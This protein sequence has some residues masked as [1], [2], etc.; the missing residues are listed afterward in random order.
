VGLVDYAPTPATQVS[1]FYYVSDSMSGSDSLIHSIGLL[2]SDARGFDVAGGKLCFGFTDATYNTQF[3][4][5]DLLDSQTPRRVGEIEGSFV[6][7]GIDPTGSC[8][9]VSTEVIRPEP[10]SIVGIVDLQAESYRRIDVRTRPCSFMTADFASWNPQSGA[11]A[12]SA[13]GF[14][15]E[16]DVFPRQLWIKRGIDCP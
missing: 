4:V 13:G 15:G 10:G 3:Y 9:I 14:T 5:I 6:S 8:A 7:V 16:G 2:P 12:F 11:F 1:G